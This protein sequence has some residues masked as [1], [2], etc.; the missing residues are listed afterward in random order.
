MSSPESSFHVRIP[1]PPQE[2]LAAVATAAE[3]WGAVW[4]PGG[5]G[6]RLQLPV[7]AG[8]RQGHQDGHVEISADDEGSELRFREER[9]ELHLWAQAVVVLALGAFGGLMTVLWPFWPDLLEVAPFGAVI[10]LSAW[11]LVMGRLENR[12]AQEFLELVR[13]VAT[14]DEE[15][16]AG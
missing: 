15:D 3:E 1:I 7:R 6:G 14:A 5:S 10:A 2:A 9:S 11:L 4:H 13:A 16:E 8:L 12:G